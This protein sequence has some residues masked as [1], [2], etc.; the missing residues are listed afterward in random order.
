MKQEQ[1]F[2]LTLRRVRRLF[3]SS[4][5]RTF[6]HCTPYGMGDSLSARSKETHSVA[7]LQPPKAIKLANDRKWELLS[8]SWVS[9]G[10]RRTHLTSSRDRPQLDPTD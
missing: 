1:I 9:E 2:G 10:P 3:Y 7:A 6:T 5:E 4:L 8:S